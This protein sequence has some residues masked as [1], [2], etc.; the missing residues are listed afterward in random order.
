M[1]SNTRGEFYRSLPSQPY[2]DQSRIGSILSLGALFGMFPNTY[3]MHRV[4]SARFMCACSIVWSAMSLSLAAC[5]NWSGLMAVRFFMGMAECVIVPSVTLIVSRFYTKAEQAPRN[6]WIFGSWSSLINGFLAWAI[7]HIREDAP[8]HRW[9]Y[10]FLITGSV[11]MAWSIFVWFML[12]GT[13]M[14]A[15][16]LSDEEK[17][18]TLMRVAQNHTGIESREW[19]WD[20]VKEAFVDPKTWILFFFDVA[21][22]VSAH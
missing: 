14:N 22:N 12:P 4:P 21:I 9:Q 15:S 20:Q 7:G 13:P 1:D 19:K 10:L 11:S 2:T 6:A 17:Y 5:T 8:L 16:F 3:L 18:H